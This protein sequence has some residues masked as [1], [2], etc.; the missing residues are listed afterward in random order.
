MYKKLSP[1][2]LR[3]VAVALFCLGATLAPQQGFAQDG[4]WVTHTVVKGETLYRISVNNNISVAEIK[5]INGLTDNTIQIGQV[6]RLYRVAGQPATEPPVAEPVPT[7][8]TPPI[9][10]NATPADSGPPVDANNGAAPDVEPVVVPVEAPMTTTS[11]DNPDGLDLQYHHFTQG[12]T[13]YSVSVKYGTTVDSLLQVNGGYA[14][15][16]SPGDSLLVPVKR[17]GGEVVTH[18]TPNLYESGYLRQ[19]PANYKSRLMANGE[20][21]DAS[22]FIVSH[23]NLPF[24]TLV[25]LVC[26]GNGR[27]AFA[28]V[29]DR[30]PEGSEYL[31]DM[32]DAVANALKLDRA[33]DP[34][35]EIRIVQ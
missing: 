12:E 10:N 22:K 5:R 16:F 11:S 24:G 9:N 1:R 19:Y 7:Q 34:K 20:R 4:D 26:P 3:F 25:L 13:L 8:P 17:S 35:V 2:P 31:M 18:T 29:A 21:Y 27:S 14:F 30:L 23:E 6:L 33:D 28:E 15:R 32:S